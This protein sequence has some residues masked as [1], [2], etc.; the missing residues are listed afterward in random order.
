[1]RTVVPVVYAMIELD[2]EPTIASAFDEKPESGLRD[3]RRVR[4]VQALTEVA[5]TSTPL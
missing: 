1:L 4:N 5:L 3:M 2:G